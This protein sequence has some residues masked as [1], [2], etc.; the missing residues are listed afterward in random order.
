MILWILLIWFGPG[1]FAVPLSIY[2]W[3]LEL[4]KS[5]ILDLPLLVIIRE[6]GRRPPPI[7]ISI[8][9]APVV[10]LYYIIYALP[11]VLIPHWLKIDKDCTLRNI[12]DKFK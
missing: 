5:S 8:F 9:I 7:L 2:H 1:I 3:K 6:N 12:I 4:N 11:V 10:F